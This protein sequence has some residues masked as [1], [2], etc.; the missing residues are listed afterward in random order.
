MITPQTFSRITQFYNSMHLENP[1]KEQPL[2][3]SFTT[4][5]IRP[6]VRLQLNGPRTSNLITFINVRVQTAVGAGLWPELHV[7]TA[8]AFSNITLALGVSVCVSVEQ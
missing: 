1:D 6:E 8:G 4:T 7:P 5:S 3:Q 2:N